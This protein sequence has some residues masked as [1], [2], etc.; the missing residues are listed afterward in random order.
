[1][2][3]NANVLDVDDDNDDEESDNADVDGDDE[4]DGD[5]DNAGNDVTNLYILAVRYDSISG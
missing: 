4:D 3:Y 1:M 5:D 2:L